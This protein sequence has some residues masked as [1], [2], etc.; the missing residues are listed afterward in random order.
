MWIEVKGIAVYEVLHFNT[1]QPGPSVLTISVIVT[2]FV[3]IL[4]HPAW[5][6]SNRKEILNRPKPGGIEMKEVSIHIT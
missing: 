5:G 1:V 6:Q 4:E 3:K 2:Y